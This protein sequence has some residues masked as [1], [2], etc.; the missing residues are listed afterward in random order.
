[1][2]CGK[3]GK[4]QK[5]ERTT[6]EKEAE[7]T[8]TWNSRE[9][10]SSCQDLLESSVSDQS[11]DFSPKTISLQPCI[12]H[13]REYTH[14][15]KSSLKKSQACRIDIIAVLTQLRKASKR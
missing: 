5:I 4:H 11:V 12:N 10:Y 6:Q 13:E 2:G 7:P 14:K 15:Q 9:T 8:K 1:L 3:V